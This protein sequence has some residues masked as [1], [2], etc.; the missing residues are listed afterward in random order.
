MPIFHS[1]S[2][3]DYNILFIISNN[4]IMM[5]NKINLKINHLK[6]SKNYLSIKRLFIYYKKKKNKPISEKFTFSIISNLYIN[7]QISK[8]KANAI[9]NHLL[10]VR[11]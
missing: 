4:K 7:L 6:I 1:V 3:N 9:N 8:I 10:L 5:M 2:I 11:K